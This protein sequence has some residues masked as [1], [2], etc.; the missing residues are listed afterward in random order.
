MPPYYF[1]QRGDTLAAIGE[2][3]GVDYRDVIRW[4]DIEDPAN[5]E[6]SQR[7]RL[8]PPRGSDREARDEIRVK[9]LPKATKVAV[10]G[11]EIP[12]QWLWPVQGP[13][14]REFS[15]QGRSRNTGIDIAAPAGTEVLAAAP[16]RVVYAG[17]G[18]RGYGNLVILRHSSGFLTTY[19]YNR[20]NLVAEDD[21]VEAGEPVARIGQTG[22][23]EEDAL[24][25]EVRRRA[26]PVDPL[27]VLPDR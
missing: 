20:E 7:L 12:M 27:T 23:T 18:L 19:A 13:I 4:N 26:D 9:G 3:F 24:H 25:F 11:G 5:L 1:V 14:V 2:R 6:V 10:H 8:V 16:G 17:D 22:S 15:T 21:W